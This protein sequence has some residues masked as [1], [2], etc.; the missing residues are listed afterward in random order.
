MGNGCAKNKGLSDDKKLIQEQNEIIMELTEQNKILCNE[1]SE[2]CFK[3]GLVMKIDSD[4]ESEF[5]EVRKKMDYK[6]LVFSGGSIKGISYCGSLEVLE[7]CGVLGRVKGFAGTSA[8]SITASLVALG[9]SAKEITDLMK[10]IDFKSLVDD[11][12]GVV[13]DG[14]NLMTDYGLAPGDVIFE[15]RGKYIGDKT[16]NPDYTL[17]QLYKDRGVKLVITGTNLS[18]RNSIYF[19]EIHDIPIRKAVRIS[20]S[21]PFLFEPCSTD[22]GLCVDGGLIDNYPLHVFD[23]ESPD[24]IR[25]RMN[26]CVPN[27]RVLGLNI[28]TSS[29]VEDLILGREHKIESLY[30]FCNS[31]IDTFM[32]DNERRIMTPSYWKRTININTK[33]YPSTDF[34]LNDEQ[35]DELIENGRKAVLDFFGLPDMASLDKINVVVGDECCCVGPDSCSQCPVCSRDESSCNSPIKKDLEIAV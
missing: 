11:K 32:I 20:M 19:Y 8:G 1:N 12:F 34:S 21:I 15:L 31:I 13:R 26:L 2:Y 10:E 35:K 14:V 27:P 25:S 3:N 33:N 23:G 9:F 29:N 4:L 7:R 5:E 16:G 30:Q 28:M 6:C 18:K 24:D 22:Y 17:S